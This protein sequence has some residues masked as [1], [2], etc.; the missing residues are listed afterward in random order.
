[1]RALLLG[2]GNSRRKKIVHELTPDKEFDELVTL[3]ITEADIVHN[4]DNLPYP[5]LDASFDEIHA[6]EVLEHCGSQGDEGFFFEQFNEFHRILKHKGMM[7]FSVPDYQSVWAFGDPGH[8]RVLPPT[9]FNFLE[10]GFY[11]QL[12]ET[13]CAD[14][15]HLI[16][17]Y[18]KC[19][20][21]EQGEQNYIL[22]QRA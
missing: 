1:M 4:L 2:A 8:K 13:A 3:D 11:D 20:G 7:C 22:L 5:F 19:I 12:G 17:G 16:K 18:W 6:Y 9:V 21:M 14:Y 15:R 10:E